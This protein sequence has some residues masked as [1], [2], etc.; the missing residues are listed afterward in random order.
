MIDYKNE[1]GSLLTDVLTII[2]ES[3]E[4][5]SRDKLAT[6]MK[7]SKRIATDYLKSLYSRGYI[8]DFRG[9]WKDPKTKEEKFEEEESRWIVSA[10]GLNYL[11]L[12]KYW[13][14]R[15]WT[16]SVVCPLIVSFVMSV[17][18]SFNIEKIRIV[19][20]TITNLLGK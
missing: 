18:T 1:L 6:I 17:F 8:I 7:V 19:I 3:K 11:D 4:P 14:K 13:W 12:H 15:F 10:D 2:K 16:R 9:D 5:I 20:K